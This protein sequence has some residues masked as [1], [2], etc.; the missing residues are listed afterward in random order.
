MFSEHWV[1][2]PAVDLMSPEGT[3][4]RAY[5]EADHIADFNADRA[6]GSYP[7]FANAA[8]DRSYD[9][10]G[11]GLPAK[12]FVTNWVPEFTAAPDGSATAVVCYAGGVSLDGSFPDNYTIFKRTI[13]FQRKGVAPPAHQKGPARAPLVSVF[14]DWYTSKFTTHPFMDPDCA[15][16]PPPVDKSPVST[17]GWS[18]TP[19]V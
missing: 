10:G 7:G 4:L 15:T 11:T 18:D 5:T 12:G 19:G 8:R 13:T 9:W 17:P 3:Y 6:E 16:N 2:T 14:G 1:S